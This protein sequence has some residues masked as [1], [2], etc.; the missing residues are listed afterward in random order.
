MMSMYKIKKHL[1]AIAIISIA[2]PIYAQV[3]PD[4]LPGNKALPSSK[5]IL[6][7]IANAATGTF[8]YSVEDYFSTPEKSSFDMSDDGRSFSYLKKEKNGK[9]SI[10][11]QDIK[12]GKTNK[13]LTEGENRILDYVWG[14]AK[15]LVYFQDNGGN[16]NYHLFA[17]DDDGKNNQDLT[18]YQNVKVLTNLI[19]LKNQPDYLIIQM[20]KDNPQIFEPYKININTGAI[21]KL[22]E[23]KDPKNS[24][25]G[26]KFN[27]E[28]KL[29]AYTQKENGTDAVIYYRASETAP[30]KQV[31]KIGWQDAF[32]IITFAYNTPYEHDAYVLTNLENNTAEVVLYDLIN[33]KII[34]K[35][36]KNE[37]FDIGGISSSLKRNDE[38]DYYYYHGE[39]ST[40]VPV[41]VT[42]K[43]LFNRFSKQFKG[44]QFSI[45][46][47]SIN[48]D[49][50]LIRVSSDRLF[51]KYYFYDVVSDKFTMILDVMP[52]LKEAEMAEMRP[53]Q[54]TSR[55]GLKIYGYLTIPKTANHEQ[56][57]L[58]VNPHG[59]PYGSRDYWGFNKEAQLFASRG[60]ATLKINYRGSGGYGN[61]FEDAG[62]KQIGRKMLEDLEDGVAYAKSLGF[63]DAKKVAIYGISYGGLA[64]LGSLV[65]TPDLYACGVDYVGV[66]NLF[67]FIESFPAYWKPLMAQFYQQWYDPE[68]PEEKKIMAEVSPAL[69]A[70]K[71][72][73]PVFVI[74][75]ANDP[76]VNI[77]ESD[78][79]VEKLRDKGIAVPYMVKYNEGHGFGHEDNLLEL[80]K[81][82]LGFFALHLK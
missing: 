18:P 7:K 32:S 5:E 16:Q 37:I 19:E 49:K 33:K 9:Q 70:D 71:I 31:L 1:L 72:K 25:S 82:M 48:E 46:K 42:F 26:Y 80:Y 63:I 52:N 12:T 79:M 17:V 6:L 74:Q 30:F 56:V 20:N 10:Y 51:G 13:I 22:F 75:G 41:S 34:K 55:D 53:I 11:V 65:K 14:N 60:Y 15:R 40:T 67:T 4:S 44:Y 45:S 43:K 58:I 2:V 54:F 36:Y 66:S 64:T 39:K 81:T 23:N 29:K 35:L 24:I 76:R 8:P 57:P 59:G 78:Q 27:Q 68:K 77:N 62:S 47:K 69:N 61:Q 3:K 21:V 50:Y 38:I 73:K 28:G